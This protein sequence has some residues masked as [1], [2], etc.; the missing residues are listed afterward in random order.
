VVDEVLAVGDAEFQNK[1][2][3]KM[4]DISKG[5]GRTVLFVSHNLTSIQ[6]LCPKSVLMKNGSIELI[7]ETNKVIDYYTLNKE[8][9][10][11]YDRKGSKKIVFTDYGLINYKVDLSED[12]DIWFKVRCNELVG[13]VDFSF[14][15]L[16]ENHEPIAHLSNQDDEFYISNLLLSGKEFEISSIIRNINLAP[17]N[18]FISLWAGDSYEWF[19]YIE[20]CI[21]FTVNQ[22]NKMIL[23]PSAYDI[24]S[25]VV[26]SSNW[27]MLL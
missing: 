1:A 12:L 16:N 22:G 14:D 15:I 13:K 2:I 8:M 24:H 6:L 18:Y 27:K 23:R 7:D 9:N 21:K 4:Q 25:K 26:L 10:K 11:D 20:N 5:Q 3:G 19:D 17:G